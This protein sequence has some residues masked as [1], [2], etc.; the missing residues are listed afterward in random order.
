MDSQTSVKN[1]PKGGLQPPQPSPWIS[2][3][4]LRK[5]DEPWKLHL[6]PNTCEMVNHWSTPI[7]IFSFDSQ[8]LAKLEKVSFCKL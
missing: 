3:S 6:L 5:E 1:F 4:V 2:A 8:S 7:N